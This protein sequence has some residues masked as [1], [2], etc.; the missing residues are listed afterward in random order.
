M[1]VVECKRCGSAEVVERDGFMQCVYCQTRFEVE[2]KEGDAPS[3]SIGILSDIDALIKKCDED[4]FNR[5]RYVKM[6][7]NIDPDNREVQRILREEAERKAPRKS[8]R[9]T[10]PSGEASDK[11]WIVA[12][13]L[14]VFVGF[15]GIDRL[16]LGQVGLGVVK[17][18]TLGGFGLWWIVD[19]GLIAFK[20]ARDS[21]GRR[22]A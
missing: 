13:V 15:F 4:P 2:S 11:S 14:S 18:L 1:K 7:L 9:T 12:L 22:L 17:F 8:S 19:I 16:Y 3:T 6:I 5:D 20:R 21:N 10:V